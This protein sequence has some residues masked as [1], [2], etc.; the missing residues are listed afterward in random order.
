MASLEDEDY[1]QALAVVLAAE[2]EEQV[3]KKQDEAASMALVK[4]LLREEKDGD[5]E[6]EEEEEPP[7]LSLEQDLQID[8]AKMACPCEQGYRS[9][10]HH[11]SEADFSLMEQQQY[12]RSSIGGKAKGRASFYW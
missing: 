8:L 5:D 9:S 1:L 2:R 12:L 6:E 7:R 3:R 4:Q 10:L 11:G